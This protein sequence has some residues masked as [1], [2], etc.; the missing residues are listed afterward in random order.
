MI[1]SGIP[2]ALYGKRSDK[3]FLFV[4]GQFG[5]KEEAERFAEVT[6]PLGWQVLAIDLPEHGGRQDGVKL[7]LG[8]SY[9]SC[10]K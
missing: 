6:N 8:R 5:C 2:A 1:I 7:L 10:K 3:V 9:P 4:H